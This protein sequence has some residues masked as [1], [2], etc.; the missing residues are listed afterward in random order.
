MKK[1]KQIE[2]LVIALQ[3]KENIIK[4]L[5]AKLGNSDVQIA[6]YQQIVKEL[7]EKLSM[8]QSKYGKVF[9]RSED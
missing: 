5:N 8:Y 7:S 3:D 2:S 9:M 6:D 1:D 4:K